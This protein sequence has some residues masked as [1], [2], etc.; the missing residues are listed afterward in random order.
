MA[1]HLQKEK[2]ESLLLDTKKKISVQQAEVQ[3]LKE[4]LIYQE[5]EINYWK[6]KVKKFPI[7]MRG[8][9]NGQLDE[10]LRSV[11]L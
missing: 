7:S 3:R 9:D 6:Q 11:R 10:D 1:F 2:C 4:D 5:Q 8:D